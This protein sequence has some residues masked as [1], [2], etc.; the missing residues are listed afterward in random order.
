MAGQHTGDQAGLSA[1][2]AASNASL[3][4]VRAQLDEA[5]RERQKLVDDVTQTQMQSQQQLEEAL[6]ERQKLADDVTQLQ[7]QLDEALR[8]RQRLADDVTQIQIK[9]EQQLSHVSTHFHFRFFPCYISEFL[10]IVQDTLVSTVT[11]NY[12]RERV[13]RCYA[14]AVAIS[15][16]RFLQ[17]K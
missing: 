9:S 1:K 4:Q 17:L 14:V 11:C 13:G 5:L 2:L 6:R 10:L 8:E 15:H 3:E 12:G 7:Q 16:L